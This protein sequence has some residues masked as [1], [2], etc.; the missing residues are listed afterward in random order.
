MG[1]LVVIG[2]GAWGTALAVAFSRAHCVSLW[3]RSEAQCALMQT[4][5]RSAYLNEI[6]LPA[7]VTIDHDLPHLLAAAQWVVV[8]TPTA[9]LR[10]AL[11]ALRAAGLGERPV[12]WACKGLEP[13]SDRF[14]HVIAEEELGEQALAG[15]L[16]GPSFALEVARGL[17]TALTLAARSEGFARDTARALHQRALRVYFSTD[18]IGVEVGGAVK[19]VLAIATGMCDA[20]AFGSNARA[21]LMT[22]GIAE[23]TRL[24]MTLGG[25]AQT[26]MGLTGVGDL[27]LTCTGDLSRNRRVGLAL[28]AGQTLEQIL[29]TLGHVAEGVSAAQGVRRIA[30]AHGVDMPITDAVC[31]V[32]AGTLSVRDAAEV[33]LGRDPRA[34]QG[35][36][37]Y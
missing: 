9:G 6:E 27:I 25:H 33:L 3:A 34:E 23:M 21:A 18:I 31:D 14:A 32:L 2:A 12:L 7:G 36:I 26:C 11:R 19:N 15:A 16:S 37:A 4:T 30:H 20:L 17:P 35:S 28:G 5:R 13:G 1:N 8:A 22:R 10:S 29:A 24:A